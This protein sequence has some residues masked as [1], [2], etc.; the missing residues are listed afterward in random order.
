MK[1]HITKEQYLDMFLEQFW[2]RVYP[3]TSY[4]REDL[5]WMLFQSEEYLIKETD[6]VKEVLK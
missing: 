2:A 1:Q 4:S 6:A 5:E 3:D